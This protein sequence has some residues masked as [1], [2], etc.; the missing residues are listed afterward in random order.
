ML[1]CGFNS[2]F[3]RIAQACVCNHIGGEAAALAF[4]H[5]IEGGSGGP[6][7]R[8]DTAML[9]VLTTILTA[10]I[11]ISSG[12]GVSSLFVLGR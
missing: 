12:L 6:E 11:V 9:I 2:D 5:L 10:I 1:F 3:E 4:P 7:G 8:K